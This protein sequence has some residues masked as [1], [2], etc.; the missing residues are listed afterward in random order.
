[1]PS[2]VNYY[3]RWWNPRSE[4][5]HKTA[6]TSPLKNIGSYYDGFKNRVTMQAYANPEAPQDKAITKSRHVPTASG[7]GIVRFNKTNRTITMECW[8]RG[9]DVT[10][11]KARQYTGWPI[12]ITQAD[13]YGRKAKAWL[14]KLTMTGKAD[15]VVQ[16]ID[17]A[18]KK[19]VYTIRIKGNAFQPKVFKPG[20]YT[21]V[22]GEGKSAKTITGVKAACCPN[23]AGTKTVTN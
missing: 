16:I 6:R 17:E 18:T 20:T 7:H 15:P 3:K 19:T 5:L 4:P 9:S 2:I 21:I 8:P 12:T 22:G 1:M 13:N 11:P 23:A 14:P 10:D